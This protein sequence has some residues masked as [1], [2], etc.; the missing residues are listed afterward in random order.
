MRRNL[1]IVRAGDNSLH[2]HW[3][4]ADPA[5]RSF[6]LVV[7]YY[8]DDPA[9]Y[10]RDDVVRIDSKGPKWPALHA[11]LTDGQLDWSGYERIWLPDDDLACEP[12]AIEQFF[13]S[14]HEHDLRLAQPSLSHDSYISH[15][16][17]A[18]NPHFVVRHTN[19]VEVMAPAFTRAMLERIVP[20]F[21]ENKSG[22]GLDYLWQM[23]IDN[24]RW[25]SGIVDAAQIRHTRPVGGPNYEAVKKAGGFTA[26]QEFALLRQKYFLLDLSQ[27]VWNG[28]LHDGRCLSLNDAGTALHLV[29]LVMDILE[30]QVNDPVR[31]ADLLKQHVDKSRPLTVLA[32]TP[33]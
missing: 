7:N 1:V 27:I 18:H 4:S 29:G 31:A 10:R 3:I 17:T 6:D 9:R 19:F 15:A 22:W 30:Q 5:E 25:Q 13:A 24:P 26:D 2:E 16:L 23:Y 21:Q 12:A 20:T 33:A 32:N 28:V 8:G 14:C 11:L